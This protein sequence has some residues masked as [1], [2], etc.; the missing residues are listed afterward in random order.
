MSDA[1]NQTG[2]SGDR[3]SKADQGKRPDPKKDAGK[4]E[5]Q[6]PRGAGDPR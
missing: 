5:G 4:D 6:A 1:D 2:G 3:F